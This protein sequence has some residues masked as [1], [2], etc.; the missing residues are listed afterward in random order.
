MENEL[1]NN[2][3]AAAI[4]ALNKVVTSDVSPR[5]ASKIVRFRQILS[6]YAATG[7]K[8]KAPKPQL[9]FVENANAAEIANNAAANV[10]GAKDTNGNEIPYIYTV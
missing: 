2:Y 10:E 3:L 9:I 6:N 8:A 1:E 7:G 4:D 5:L